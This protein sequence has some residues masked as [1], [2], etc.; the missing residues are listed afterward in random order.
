MSQLPKT[1]NLASAD[2]ARNLFTWSEALR[3]E[4]PVCKARISALSIYLVTRYDDCQAILKDPRIVRNRTTATGGS[5][6][7]FPTP[8]ALQPMMQS[9]IQEDDPNHRRLREL[10]RRAFSPRAIEQ[11]EARIDAYTTRLLDSF[12]GR[13]SFDL[14]KEYAEPIPM[15]MISDMMGLDQSAAPEL[16]KIIS[17]LTEG[18]TGVKVLKSIF[19]ELPKVV[20]FTRNLVQEK[21]DQPGDDILTALIQAE[22]DG[23]RLTEDELVSMVI[24]LIIGGF[25]TTVHL[26]TNGV[27]ALTDHPDQ[28]ARLQR[29]SSLGGSLVEEVLRHRGPIQSTKP[30]YTTEE[31]ELH[32]VTIPKGKPVMPLFAAAN[33]DPR[34][35]DHPQAFD[36]GRS[37]NRH[38]GF[39]HGIHFC[40]GAH[41]A[42][43]EARIGLTRLF[44]R[45][46]E[47]KP[48]RPSDQLTLQTMPGWHRYQ[49]LE[50][51]PTGRKT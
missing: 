41:L 30:G 20:A 33:H 26:I 27:V 43:A 10:V 17:T 6:V 37:P 31:I 15:R 19:L 14:Q 38:L 4:R 9:M 8:K 49:G 12:E 29:D 48:A 16:K 24:L 28:L 36:I 46:P 13:R 3:E 42:R 7:P 32:G 47:L 18:F 11:L 44:E 51:T 21:R 40:L 34:A 39:G 45:Y 5:R 2:F 35:F 22:E 25:E 1:I 23:D 50:V